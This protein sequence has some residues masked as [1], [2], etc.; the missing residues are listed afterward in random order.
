M[1]DE[2]TIQT[3]CVGDRCYPHVRGNRLWR[4]ALELAWLALQVGIPFFIEQ[5]RGSKAWIW[6]ETQLL[7]NSP[8][9]R[10]FHFDWCQYGDD[11]RLG[12][13]NM[14]P[15]RVAGSGGWLESLVRTCNRRHAHGAL[16]RGSRAKL[17]GAY[18][19][20]FCRLFAEAVLDWH[21]KAPQCGAL[22]SLS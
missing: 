12:P 8:S 6:K 1:E 19:H 4:R 16:L 7:L 21:G 14:K 15:T 2:K 18:P 20:E 3:I 22:S 10:L 13:P 5:S 11:E 9:V 17:A